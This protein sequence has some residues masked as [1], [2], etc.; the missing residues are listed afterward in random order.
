MPSLDFNFTTDHHFSHRPP[1]R[2]QG[3]YMVDLSIK[4]NQVSAHCNAAGAIPLFGGDLFHLKD[5]AKIA[6]LTML[7]FLSGMSS[8]ITKFDTKPL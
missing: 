5:P 4:M 2:R 1:G 7:K 8:L 3:D 6:T